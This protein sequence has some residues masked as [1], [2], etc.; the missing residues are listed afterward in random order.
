MEI[1]STYKSELM[2]STSKQSLLLVPSPSRWYIL[3]T[4]EFYRILLEVMCFNKEMK[5]KRAS[6]IEIRKYC[7]LMLTQCIMLGSGDSSLKSGTIQ[8]VPD[9]NHKAKSAFNV[10][11]ILPNHINSVL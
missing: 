6:K 7:F 11:I 1:N 2:V 5:R 8:W 4:R 9:H 10:M 3:L